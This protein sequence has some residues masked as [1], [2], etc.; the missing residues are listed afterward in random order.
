MEPSKNLWNNVTGT[1]KYFKEEGKGCF[2]LLLFFIPTKKRFPLSPLIRLRVR[3]LNGFEGDEGDDPGAF[4]GP[5]QE[6]LVMSASPCDATGEKLALFRDKTTQSFCILVIN[7]VHSF[8]AKGANFSLGK[9][10]YRGGT[11]KA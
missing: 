3:A 4:D 6:S 2:S 5:G 8:D 9:P 1:I 7:D 10:P 11:A